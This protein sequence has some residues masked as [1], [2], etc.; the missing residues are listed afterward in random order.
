MRQLNSRISTG[1]LPAV[2]L[3]LLHSSFIC[4]DTTAPFT[5]EEWADAKFKYLKLYQSSTVVNKAAAIKNISD[6]Y[7]RLSESDDGFAVEAMEFLLWLLTVE[8]EE[9]VLNNI[10]ACLGKFSKPA[11][12]E[13]LSKNY[14]RLMN[15][16]ASKLRFI[17]I[18][19][20]MTGPKNSALVN[21]ICRDLWKQDESTAVKDA[22]KSLLMKT[23]GWTALDDLIALASNSDS[24]VSKAAL[25]SLGEIYAWEKVTELIALLN[26]MQ[27]NNNARKEL[28]SA[29]EKITGQ[30]IGDN[31]P[32]W[33][34]WWDTKPQIPDAALKHTI[35]RAI[36]RGVEYLISQPYIAKAQPALIGN[37]QTG[38]LV[39]YALLKSGVTIP[40]SL[41]KTFIDGLLA[42]NLHTTYNVAVMAMA[43][44]ELD[45]VKYIERIA[46]C[47]QFILSNQTTAGGW[48]Y[49]VK[50]PAN[51]IVITNAPRP[52]APVSGTSTAPVKKISIKHTRIPAVSGSTGWDTSIAQ[53][54]VLGLR[55]CAESDIEIPLEAWRDAEKAFIQTQL[56][57][58]GWSCC[59]GNSSNTMTAAGLGSLAICLYFQ[60]KTSQDNK[61]IEQALKW[62]DKNFAVPATAMDHGTLGYY[63]YGIE[64]AGTLLLTDY[65]ASKPWYPLGARYLL[66]LQ[67]ED[68]SWGYETE[69]CFAILFL[70]KATKPLKV[71]ITE[72]TDKKK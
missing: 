70:T 15:T 20:I 64:R 47:A 37:M 26:G 69:T 29:L 39:F 14:Q 61:P 53:Y 45:R 36:K 67:R 41:R 51:K 71:I 19:G 54:A 65:F 72:P 63:L 50:I 17:E 56:S 34:K 46:Q 13:W 2:I 28:I 40:E 8:K 4:A 21:A 5:K 68:G 25:K 6:L 57:D 35:D 3:L 30:S 48:G 43:F 58:S 10:K 23:T 9:P 7:A 32:D 1:F 66:G 27:L 49:G 31:P 38:E 60:G 55:A 16:E 22:A 44:A 59:G 11:Y 24:E 18:L 42:K 12:V 52:A 62:M 33:Q